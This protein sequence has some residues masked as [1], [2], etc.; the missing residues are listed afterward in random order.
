MVR[1]KE[2]VTVTKNRNNCQISF[3]LRAKELKKRGLTPQDLL[4]IKLYK[5]KRR[6]KEK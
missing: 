2:L 6:I 1:I 3:V 5:S 4:N